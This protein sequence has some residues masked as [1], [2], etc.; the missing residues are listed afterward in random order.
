MLIGYLRTQSLHAL[1]N[2]VS[3][4][5]LIGSSFVNELV[6]ALTAMT[7]MWPDVFV[8]WERRVVQP[9][10]AVTPQLLAVSGWIALYP[11]PSYTVCWPPRLRAL[12]LSHSC[13]LWTRNRCVRSNQGQAL[14]SVLSPSGLTSCSVW[15]GFLGNEIGYAGQELEKQSLYRQLVVWLWSESLH[16]AV[17]FSLRQSLLCQ[18]EHVFKDEKCFM[19]SVSFKCFPICFYKW[20]CSFF[21]NSFI[22]M[23]CCLRHFRSHRFLFNLM[24]ITYLMLLNCFDSCATYCKYRLVPLYIRWSWILCTYIIISTMYLLC[25]YCIEKHFCCSWGAIRVRL[26]TGLVV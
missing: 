4:R 25:S 7:A 16:C 12:F 20:L 17:L 3:I 8:W 5:A 22:I 18:E 11:S 19:F 10:H 14:F 6:G 1:V 13:V 15:S 24:Q 23:Q 9:A 2:I 21:G 26:G